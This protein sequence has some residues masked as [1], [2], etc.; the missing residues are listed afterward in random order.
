MVLLIARDLWLQVKI[1]IDQDCQVDVCQS[2]I[3]QED[4]RRWYTIAT[5]IL[6]NVAAKQMIAET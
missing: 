2:R 6:R 5:L 1:V 4:E 3:F